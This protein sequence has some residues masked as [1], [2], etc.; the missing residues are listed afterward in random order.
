MSDL[1]NALHGLY[2]SAISTARGFKRRQSPF[3][4]ELE[5]AVYQ[6]NRMV[7][8]INDELLVEAKIIGQISIRT[9]FAH[10]S[11]QIPLH[12]YLENLTLICVF[13]V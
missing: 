11:F 8:V 12:D 9:E 1:L 2:S 10:P 4:S 13:L 5:T 3:H 6:Y 7:E